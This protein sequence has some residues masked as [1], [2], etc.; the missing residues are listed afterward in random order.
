[1][2]MESK[3]KLLRKFYGNKKLI[4]NKL[5]GDM[6]SNIFTYHLKKFIKEGLIEKK[7]N[8]YFLTKK[9]EEAICY[10]DKY[11]NFSSLKQPIHDVFLV[12]IKSGKFLV[13]KRT[14][15]PFLGV[16]MPIGGKLRSGEVIFECVK[17]KLKE[18][19]GLTG[20]FKLKGLI[21]VRTYKDG[22]LFLHHILN[23]FKIINL[24]G[25]LIEKTDKG[26][27]FW[28]SEKEYFKK[29]NIMSAMKE[30]LE[31]IKSKKF[32]FLELNQYMENDKF[33]KSEIVRKIKL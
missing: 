1:M 26:E 2:K 27:N 12:P 13:M 32:I 3:L 33:V 18:D 30:H 14:K 25:D 29:K 8:F 16:V 4:F 5:K 19:T 20:E 28:V 10:L 7:N 11:S 17:R 6:P 23:V 24:K 22:K 21:D 9:G 15:R 31:I